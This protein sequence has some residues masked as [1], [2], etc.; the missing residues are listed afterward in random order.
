MIENNCLGMPTRFG[1]VPA[2]MKTFFDSC[3]QLWMTGGLRNKHVATFF[4]TNSIGAGQETTAFTTLPFFAHMGMIYV[5][6]GGK[7]KGH[8]DNSQVHGGSA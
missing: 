5:T 1:M 8:S 3:G 4:S 2:Q 7:F 6:F